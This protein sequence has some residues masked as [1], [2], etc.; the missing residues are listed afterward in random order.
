MPG[1]PGTRHR[2]ARPVEV[3]AARAWNV[4]NEG[5]PFSLVYPPMVLV[6]AALV[7]L[8]PDGSLWVTLLTATASCLVLSHFAFPLR[9]RVLRTCVGG[10]V[11]Y[12]YAG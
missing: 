1:M 6:A 8:S 7:G 2:P 12:G 5:R 11:V 4:F 9:G 10:R 3:W